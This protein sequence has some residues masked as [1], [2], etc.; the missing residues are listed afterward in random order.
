M[1]VMAP[2]IPAFMMFL[3]G[4]KPDD[5]NVSGCWHHID[6]GGQRQLFTLFLADPSTGREGLFRI[7]SRDAD[8]LLRSFMLTVRVTTPDGLTTQALNQ[9]WGLVADGVLEAL[10]KQSWVLYTKVENELAA[11]L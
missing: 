11:R 8:A 4:N 1:G 5:L 3:V 2:W 9:E 6:V 10:A 7:E